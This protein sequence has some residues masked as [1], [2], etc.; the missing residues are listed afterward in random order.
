MTWWTGSAVGFDLETDGVDTEDA[1][2]I[3]A[4][5]VQLHAGAA[6]VALELMAKPERPIPDEASAIHGISTE[7]AQAEGMERGA[8]VRGIVDQLALAGPDRPVVGHNVAFDL[9]ITDREMRRLGIGCIGNDL[10]TGLVWL[11]VAGSQ[12][13]RFPVIDTYVLDKA[14]DRYRK[15][16]RQLSVAAGHYGVPMAEGAAHGA[17]ADVIASL[18]IAI[19]IANRANEAARY[20]AEF[21]SPPRVFQ[22]HDFMR[23]YAGRRNPLD[24]VTSFGTLSAMT[25]AELHAAQAGWAAEQAEGLREH[26][27]RNPDK[28]DPAGVDGS[29]PLRAL[30]QHANSIET[31]STELI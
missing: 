27:M 16:K 19:A 17:T 4:A 2:I 22:M 11:E 7:R 21:G 9:T 3:T 30:P 6:P 26:F 20:E 31:I 13:V 15:G 1:R 10:D 8:A 12:V 14:V 28:G 25:L 24:L 18:R 29:W 5:T 23:H